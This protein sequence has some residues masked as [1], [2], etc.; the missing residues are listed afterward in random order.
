[1]KGTTPFPNALLDQAM[2]ALRDTEWRVLCVVVRATLGWQAHDGGRKVRDWLSSSQL[3]RRTGRAS[4]AVSKAIDRLVQLGLIETR[5]EVGRELPTP[6]ARRAHRSRIYYSL[7]S[8]EVFQSKTR[9]PN[10][11]KERRTKLKR[12]MLPQRPARGWH[13][14]ADV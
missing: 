13:R 6:Q 9:K 2:P 7:A 4:S 14:A 12:Q 3:R 1:M 10:T 5:T 8:L 11:T